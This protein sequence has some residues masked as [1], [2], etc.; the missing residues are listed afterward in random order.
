MTAIFQ[1]IYAIVSYVVVIVIFR[2]H[3]TYTVTS[4]PQNPGTRTRHLVSST[5]VSGGVNPGKRQTP[6]RRVWAC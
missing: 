2:K 3:A 6:P 4:Y 5:D 1:F